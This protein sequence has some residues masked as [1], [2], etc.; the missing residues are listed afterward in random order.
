MIFQETVVE[1]TC[2]NLRI[3][4]TAS[5]LKAWKIPPESPYPV[6]DAMRSRT[7]HRAIETFLHYGIATVTGPDGLER[8]VILI[9]EQVHGLFTEGEIG[10]TGVREA[11][12]YGAA[13]KWAGARRLDRDM[14]ILQA[15]FGYCRTVHRCQ[16][17]QADLVLVVLEKSVR[18]RNEEG[19]RWLY[20]AITRATKK[21]VVLEM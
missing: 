14:P 3:V 20:V 16:G 15:E 4:S 8:D 6:H 11:A 17:D 18:T 2:S 10:N 12:A 9:S 5:T 21:V 7:E 13:H 19:A 1:A